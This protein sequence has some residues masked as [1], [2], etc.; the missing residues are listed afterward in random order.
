MF[1]PVMLPAGRDRLATNPSC[2]GSLLTKKTIG[3]VVVAA[4]AA[5]DDSGPPVIIA[6]TERHPV[7]WRYSPRSA[8]LHL[9]LAS[10]T[11]AERSVSQNRDAGAPKH[12]VG[13]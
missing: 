12:I 8:A 4:L 5:N 7:A 3:T 10:G 6:A 1:I 13:R 2:T 9:P 11:R